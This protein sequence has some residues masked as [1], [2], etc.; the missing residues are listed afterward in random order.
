[1]IDISEFGCAAQSNARQAYDRRHVLR[2]AR[3]GRE[4]CEISSLY[5]L[6]RGTSL[7]MYPSG[8]RH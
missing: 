2:T 1:M 3:V 7:K 6:V 8:S 5:R 4:S